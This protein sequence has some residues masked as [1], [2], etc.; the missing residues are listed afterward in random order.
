MWFCPIHTNRIVLTIPARHRPFVIPG[1]VVPTSSFER[2]ITPA[3]NVEES[4]PLHQFVVLPIHASESVQGITD[5]SNQLSNFAEHTQG[6]PFPVCHEMTGYYQ[7]EMDHVRCCP[8]TAVPH[9]V[10]IIRG[11][12]PKSLTLRNKSLIIYTSIAM[13]KTVIVI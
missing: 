13:L 12:G 7:R 2:W 11:I 9:A 10:R 5:D 3:L 8:L 4:W 1:Y 6:L